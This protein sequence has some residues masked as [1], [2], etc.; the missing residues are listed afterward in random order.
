MVFTCPITAQTDKHSAGWNLA[1]DLPSWRAT[2]E[3][4]RTHKDK[5]LV[6]A[7]GRYCS[8]KADH[9]K[10]FDKGKEGYEQLLQ[11]SFRIHRDDKASFVRVK[12]K[13]MSENLEQMCGALSF[14]TSSGTM[15]R[16]RV[17]E[18]SSLQRL[19]REDAWR[20]GYSN[21]ASSVFLARH[22]VANNPYLDTMGDPF[23][24]V[25]SHPDVQLIPVSINTNDP[26]NIDISPLEDGEEPFVYL[27]V[28][29]P[30]FHDT[31][32]QEFKPPV[33]AH[34]DIAGFGE[35]AVPLAA[36]QSTPP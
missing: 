22:I 17:K 32:L 4:F 3:Y 31:F 10:A 36:R 13:V 23:G 5:K 30:S 33:H 25:L 11:P 27:A 9:Q 35:E 24:L 18:G 19:I 15:V 21:R 1:S 34:R 8:V 6:L 7:R 2:Y 28:A 14:L 26:Y 16:P 29:P 20:K 12:D